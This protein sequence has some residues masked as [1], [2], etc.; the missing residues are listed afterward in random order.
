MK[1]IESQTFAYCSSLTTVYIGN[2]VNRI[3]VLA[4]TDCLSL[5]DFY[6]FAENVPIANKDGF[7][8]TPVENATL[9]VPAASIEAY[10]AAEPWKNF[11]DILPLDGQSIE[12]LEYSS[13]SAPIYIYS[14]DGNLI[15]TTNSQDEA[16]S[17]VSSL[18]RGSVAIVKKG[19]K[20]VKVLNR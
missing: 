10:K 13:P 1:I 20:S 19:G 4:F 7:K 16:A 8:N 15:G 9:H 5:T 17:I 12:T 2:S 11:K 14:P 3:Q 18:S 6:C